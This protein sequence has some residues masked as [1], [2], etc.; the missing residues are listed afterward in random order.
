MYHDRTAL[1]PGRLVRRALLVLVLAAAL[2]LGCAWGAGRVGTDLDGQGAAALKNAV[3]RSAVQCYAVEGYY[4]E[5][6][7]LLTDLYGLQINHDRY[8]VV[9]E[10]FASNLPPQVTVLQK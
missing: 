6:L 1:S 10:A 2:V 7:D 3:V 9:Y 8:I 4:P 5:N